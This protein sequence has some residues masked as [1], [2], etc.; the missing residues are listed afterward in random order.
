MA[1]WVQRHAALVL[2]LVALFSG[3][4][5]MF[6][7][8]VGFGHGN[9]MASVARNFAA[10]G[11]YS[12]P[13][14]PAITGPT[15]I[16]PPL[17]PLYLALLIKLFG[18]SPLFV[19]V[20]DLANMLVN[21]LIA[22]LMPRL[23]RVFYGDEVPGVF[24]GVLWILSMRLLPQWDVSYTVLGLV[25]FFLLSAA[26]IERTN[27]AWLWAGFAWLTAGLLVLA[28]PATLLIWAPWVLF[29]IWSR[30]VPFEHAVRYGAVLVVVV[31]LCNLPWA[32]RNYGIWHE[33]VLRTNFG[34][35]FYGSNN[36]CAQSS[37][38]RNLASGCFQASIP[39]YSENEARIL[40]DLGE[41]E[42]DRKKIADTLAWIR[43]HPDRFRQLTLARV[44]DFWFPD[45]LTKTFSLS[46]F[47]LGTIFGLPG[48]L[49]MARRR[50][51]VTKFVLLVLLVY[52]LMYYLVI[53]CDRYRYPILWASHLPAG[54]LVAALI[55]WPDRLRTTPAR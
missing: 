11:N 24:A 28:N 39:T 17:Y 55:G 5:Q 47:W 15:A 54:Y 46:G 20:A 1:G 21:A 31:A 23:S 35:T 30:R 37:L 7:P 44:G 40:K 14:L 49:V 41:V 8:G 16:I 9:E 43:T 18:L 42:Y 12:N 48:L 13:F 10:T 33:P 50:E 6:H 53:S 32:I 27:G 52:P 19:I 34:M 4:C 22:A 45:G 25:L 36:D 2:F 51:P 38:A 3:C 26:T 29:L